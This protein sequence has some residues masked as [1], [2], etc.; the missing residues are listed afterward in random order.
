[1]Q[2]LTNAGCIRFADFSL[3]FPKWFYENSELPQDLDL[4]KRRQGKT[5]V[6]LASRMLFTSIDIVQMFG[7]KAG[8]AV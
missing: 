1:M 7:C 6:L 3:D 5:A 2:D 8:S 4:S